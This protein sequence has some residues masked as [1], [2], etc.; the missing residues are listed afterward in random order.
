M[1]EGTFLLPNNQNSERRKKKSIQIIKKR[2]KNNNRVEYQKSSIS[3]RGSRTSRNSDFRKKIPQDFEEIKTS[4]QLKKFKIMRKKK[5]KDNKSRN[6]FKES[7]IKTCNIN[8]FQNIS[9]N[10]KEIFNIRNNARSKISFSDNSRHSR[11]SFST[12]R[13]PLKEGINAKLDQMISNSNSKLP[14]I[15]SHKRT[16]T[17]I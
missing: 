17:F 11:L 12:K 16:T 9:P 14:S 4:T 3:S 15:K 1:R 8:K 10:S 2:T 6:V 5:N 13:N 7:H